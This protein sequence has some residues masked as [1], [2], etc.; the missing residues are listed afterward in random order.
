MRLVYWGRIVCFS[1]AGKGERGIQ[2][3]VVLEDKAVYVCNCAMECG[4]GHS[5]LVR[6][7]RLDIEQHSIARRGAFFIVIYT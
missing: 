3:W 7:F 6:I 2:T 1:G 4:S 5:R